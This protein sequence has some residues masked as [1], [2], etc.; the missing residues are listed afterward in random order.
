MKKRMLFALLV[1]ALLLVALPG[2]AAKGAGR[3]AAAF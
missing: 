3:V 1:L 2:F